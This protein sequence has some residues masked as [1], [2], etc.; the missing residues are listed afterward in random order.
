ML[1]IW[2]ASYKANFRNISYLGWNILLRRRFIIVCS[3]FECFEKPLTKYKWKYIETD[4]CTDRNVEHELFCF[5]QMPFIREWKSGRRVAIFLSDKGLLLPKCFAPS[6][7]HIFTVHQPLY[8]VWFVTRQNIYIFSLELVNYKSFVCIDSSPFIVSQ[9]CYV[10]TSIPEDEKPTTWRLMNFKMPPFNG[11][12]LYL[13]STA[14]HRRH[15]WDLKT[16]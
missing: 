4:W 1:I 3:Y 12:I 13:T 9:S 8:I 10:S 14:F 2:S 6:V 15:T 7:F 16:A 11:V 5:E